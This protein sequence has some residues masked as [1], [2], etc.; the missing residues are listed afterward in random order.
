MSLNLKQLVH[1][2]LAVLFGLGED[3]AQEVV[4]YRPAGFN[5]Q[6]GAFAESEAT[7]TG[8]MLVLGYRPFELGNITESADNEKIIMRAGELAGIDTPAPGD[9]LIETASGQRRDIL[10]A[11]ADH[12]GEYWLFQARRSNVE[13][14]GGL[15]AATAAGEDR[16]DLAAATAAEDWGTLT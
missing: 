15:A 6:T 1:Q 9:F 3:V 2:S 4:F 14:W 11:K 12:L 7:A 5:A 10:A 8:R 13:D 16:G